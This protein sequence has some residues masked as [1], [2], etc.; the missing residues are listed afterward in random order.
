MCPETGLLS[1]ERSIKMRHVSSQMFASGFCLL[2]TRAQPNGL[3]FEVAMDSQVTGSTFVLTALARLKAG[4]ERARNDVIAYA[5]TRLRVLAS[6]MLRQFPSVQRWEQTDDVLQTAMLRMHKALTETTPTDL[7]HLLR[8][9]TLQIRRTLIDLARHYRGP[10]GLGAHHQTGFQAKDNS[11]PEL[12]VDRAIQEGDPTS[13]AEWTSFHECVAKLP[14]QEREVFELLYYQGLS[15]ADAAE[16]L[17]V[18]ER[19]VRRHWTSARL[20]LSTMMREI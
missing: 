17:G 16:I 7:Q 6:Q 13:L 3:I 5:Q 4:D 2:L 10:E 19:T 15:Q 8:L 1:E 12:P 14:E 9:C 20:N 11:A 18:V